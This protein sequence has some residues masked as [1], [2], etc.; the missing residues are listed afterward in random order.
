MK[1]YSHSNLQNSCHAD[2][3]QHLCLGKKSFQNS[4]HPQKL[5]LLPRKELTAKPEQ[6]RRLGGFHPK[7]K[8]QEN[9]TSPFQNNQPQ[10]L[11]LL[12]RKELKAKPEQQ[13]GLGGFHLKTKSQEISTNSAFQRNETSAKPMYYIFLFLFLLLN[14]NTNL[15]AQ[16]SGRVL[17]AQTK[18]PLIGASIQILTK[19]IGTQTDENGQFELTITHQNEEILISFVGYSSKKV[20]LTSTQAKLGDLFLF[21]ESI[22]S[23]DIIVSAQRVDN[24]TPMAFKTLTSDDIQ[25]V[26]LGQDL[27]YLI[28]MTPSI[29]SSSDAGAGVGYTYM[30]IRG[31]DQARINVT[32]NGIPIN[33][34]ESHGVWWVNMPDFSS[35]VES[36]QIQRGVGTSTNG[37]AAFGASINMAT[38]SLSAE[39][40]ATISSSYGSFNTQKFST[41]F[42]TGLLKNGWAFD[43]RLSK[44][45]SDGYIDRANS[46]LSSYFLNATWNGKNQLLKI[47]VFSGTEKTYQAWYGTPEALVFGNQNDIQAYIDRN[48]WSL[49]ESDISN[50]KTAGRRYNYYTYDNETDNYSQHHYQIHYS[51][52]ISDE[53][54]ANVSLHYTK[55]SGYYE[56]F[57]RQGNMENYQLNP[58]IVNGNQLEETDLIRRLWLDNDFYG[59]TF[60]SEWTPISGMKILAGGAANNYI[61]DHFGEVIWAEF[62]QGTPIRNRYYD[63]TGKK[64]DVALYTKWIQEF[65][66]FTAYAD[67]QLRNIVYRFEGFTRVTGDVIAPTNLRDSLTF[68]NPKAGLTW[69][70]TKNQRVFASFSVGN[71]EA[72]RNE[73]TNSLFSNRP[74]HETMYDWEAG[75]QI[76]IKNWQFEI[77]TYFMDYKNQLLETGAINDVGE[78]VRQNVPNSYRSGIELMVDGK[79]MENLSLRTSLTL[80]RNRAVK[81]NQ[82]MDNYDLDYVNDL[83]QQEIATF[84]NSPLSQSPEI[85]WNNSLSWTYNSFSADWFS[86]Y[87]GKQYLDNTGSD[88]KSIPSYFVNDLRMG[89]DLKFAGNT[90]VNFSVLVNNIFNELY[91]PRGY[92]YSYIAGGETITENFYYPQATR[93]LLAQIKFS[94]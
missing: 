35:S 82:Y 9:K 51:R 1:L 10:K 26:N 44:I 3:S 39:P 5:P 28:Q 88:S 61:G 32:I 60:N 80:S 4:E 12:P 91:A 38:N 87:V 49:S 13:R 22:L 24:S 25:R 8:S 11:P 36:I 74:K 34:S 73:Y 86:R 77:V 54:N 65:G 40:F 67:I 94:F 27:P 41:E 90:Q 78:Y 70:P 18:K 37:T 79:L 64:S 76:G 84:S 6:Q 89:Y 59:I 62:M 15:T 69:N 66:D 81:V 52:K 45:K 92:T 14:I 30:S 58:V 31:V 20:L 83:P 63:N 75:Y 53:L 68:V 19:T 17:D 93:N 43:G 72:T 29:L 42:G 46:D 33:D 71:K 55:G 57:V 2:E 47:N 16:I 48:G 7:T 23:E 50:L 21:S 56:T 85:I